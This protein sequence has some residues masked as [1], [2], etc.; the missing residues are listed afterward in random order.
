MTLSP[1]PAISEVTLTDDNAAFDGSAETKKDDNGTGTVK[2]N[3][4]DV[5]GTLKKA[6]HSTETSITS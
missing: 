1:N 4:Y 2:I 5:L 3:I 6:S